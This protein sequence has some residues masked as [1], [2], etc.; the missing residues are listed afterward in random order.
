MLARETVT[1]LATEVS[2]TATEAARQG[3]CV[4]ATTVSSSVPTSTPRTTA[5]NTQTAV[6][7]GASGEPGVT[8]AGAVAVDSGAGT[9]TAGVLAVLTPRPRRPGYVTLSPATLRDININTRA[10]TITSLLNIMDNISMVSINLANISINPDNMGNITPDNLFNI[11]PGNL[12]NISP[13]NIK[14]DRITTANTISKII[15]C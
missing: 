4:G 10:L 5:V 11:S 15:N 12:F 2:M 9:G 8:A 3:W 13:G 14:T 1:D 7:A 6:E